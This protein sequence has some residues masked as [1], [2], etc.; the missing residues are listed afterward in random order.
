VHTLALEKGNGRLEKGNRTVFG[1]I[2]QDLHEGHP[3]VIVDG[4]V[5]DFMAAAAPTNA[6]QLFCVHVQ[7]L[8]GLIPLIA[9]DWLS[10]G[11][12]PRQANGGTDAPDA[13][14]AD[15]K[16]PSDVSHRPVTP[17]TQAAHPPSQARAERGRAVMRPTATI[18]QSGH[19][20]LVKA[21]SPLGRGARADAQCSGCRTHARR[22]RQ[23]IDMHS[24]VHR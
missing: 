20:T 22:R 9:L 16:C 7:E 21:T 12:E 19:A 23:L 3:A 17:A 5:H 4:H 6:H 8:A 18:W 24:P 10:R 14:Q 1:F 2:R 11:P 15:L 13:G